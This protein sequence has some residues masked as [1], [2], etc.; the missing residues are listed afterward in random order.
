MV[1]AVVSETGGQARVAADYRRA[2]LLWQD[3]VNAAG[4]LLG[5]RVQ[6]RLRDDES[7]ALRA[8]PLYAELIRDQ[9]DLLIGPYGSGASLQ[10]AAEA[11]RAQRVMINGAGPAKSVHKR[12]PIYIFQSVAPYSAYGAGVL[13]LA[14]AAGC[15]V[16]FIAAR[17]D[18]V[19]GEMADG[20]VAMARSQGFSVLGPVPHAGR[21]TDFV[22]Q[23]TRAR[24]G[25]ADAWIAFGGVRDTAE[26]VKA[27]K[28]H[29]Y[30]RRFFFSTAA[31]RPDF[32]TAVGQE[33]EHSLGSSRYD[34]RLATPGNENFARA[35]T[36]KWNRPPGPAAAEGYVAGS[37]LAE[38]VRRAG[39]LDQQAL[40][41]ELA[42]LEMDTLLGRYKVNPANG[43]QVGIRPAVAQIVKGLPQIVWPPAW[44]TAEASLTCR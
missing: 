2:L 21:N 27:F 39:S 10:G 4:G 32:V 22:P 6:L 25:K 42:S 43:E 34:S 44:K 20:A 35:F 37:V 13:Q 36:E 23:L 9:A 14:R 7:R 16:L 1:G 40:R 41:A 30:S 19:F 29:D 3:E 12:A 11:E 8:G 28:L 31:A 17:D 18:G 5:R 24:D 33:A 26:M 38:A 15:K